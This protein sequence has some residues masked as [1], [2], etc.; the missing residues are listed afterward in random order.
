MKRLT[1]ITYSA[2]AVFALACLAPAPEARAACQK[3][4]LTDQNTVLGD[5][6]FLNNT[7]GFENMAIGSQR[8]RCGLISMIVIASARAQTITSP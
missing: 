6:A 5:D 4:C 1:N 8:S 3:G 2:F 7:K